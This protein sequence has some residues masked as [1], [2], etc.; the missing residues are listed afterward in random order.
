MAA[1]TGY[2]Q[3]APLASPFL[4]GGPQLESQSGAGYPPSLTP[5]PPPA[6]T[7]PAGIIMIKNNVTLVVHHYVK[8]PDSD[9]TDVEEERGSNTSSNCSSDSETQLPA[10]PPQPS[11]FLRC[12][13]VICCMAPAKPQRRSRRARR[14]PSTLMSATEAELAGHV[15]GPQANAVDF[16]SKYQK[17]QAVTPIP[18]LKRS[19]SAGNLTPL[20]RTP[21]IRTPLAASRDGTGGGTAAEP[22]GT[23]YSA[24]YSAGSRF[25]SYSIPAEGSSPLP[26]C[27]SL[28]SPA[29]VRLSGIGAPSA[30]GGSGATPPSAADAVGWSFIGVL[31]AGGGSGTGVAGGSP[32][33]SGLRV[34]GDSVGL[35]TISSF[36]GQLSSGRP[37]ATQAPVLTASGLE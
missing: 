20:A 27:N 17:A 31:G 16:R 29:D 22:P 4:G 1:A 33:G 11:A 5:T 14:R 19:N 12:M 25:S 7:T 37:S 6:P 34:A 23:G 13:A 30:A 36:S 32:P 28:R 24:G 8:E 26:R 35:S 21:L 18:V 3:P 10:A 9:D 2:L 15:I